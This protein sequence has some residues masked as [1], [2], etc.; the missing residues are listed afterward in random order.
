MFERYAA[1]GKSLQVASKGHYW[2]ARAAARAGQGALANSYYQRAAATPE[3]FYGQLALERLGRPVP[4]PQGTPSLLVTTAQR[5]AFEDKRLVAAVR[6]LGRSGS[7]SEQSLFIRALSEQLDNDADRILAIEL[8]RSIGRPD[9]AVWTERSARNSGDRFFY[10]AAYP[11]H[12]FAASTGRTWS[13]AHGIT[14]QESSFDRGIVSHAGAQGMMQLMPGT[15]REY[16]GKMG[17]DYEPGRLTSDPS[18]NVS[19][20][21]YYFQHLL[22]V[23]GGSVPLAV[24]SYNAGSGNVSK[25]IRANGDPRTGSIDMVSWIERIPFEETRGYV[26]RVL[27][28]S[29][30]YDTINP[31]PSGTPRLSSYLGTTG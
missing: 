31:R 11:T 3:L 2:A 24:A 22:D 12:S 30:I 13:L 27:E 18:F 29:V 17:A 7:R 8:S 25:W 20:G 26:Q 14:R 10:R 21:T 16:A 28:G 4:P 15:A 19:L 6:Q 23:W 9:L 5:R 1:S